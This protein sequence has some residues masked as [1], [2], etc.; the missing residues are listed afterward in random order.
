M[1]QFT[2]P[3]AQ[4]IQLRKPRNPIVAPALRRQAGA[5]ASLKHPSRQQASHALRNAVRSLP[6]DDSP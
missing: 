6:P 5:H 4:T 3:R 1:P 2:S